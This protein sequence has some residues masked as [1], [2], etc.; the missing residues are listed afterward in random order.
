MIA[1][2]ARHLI[3]GSSQ[4]TIPHTNVCGIQYRVIIISLYLNVI[5]TCR[6][7]P[8]CL[9]CTVSF[10]EQSES[11]KIESCVSYLSFET[12]LHYVLTTLRDCQWCHLH[13]Y[14]HSFTI[15]LISPPVDRFDFIHMSVKH[16]IWMRC[17][18]YMIN[19]FTNKLR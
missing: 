1:Q 17:Q 18:P 14:T 15:A 7:Y 16:N 12:L 10:L 6:C 11:L 13:I 5:Y 8:T 4:R 2:I 3:L 19:E 9:S